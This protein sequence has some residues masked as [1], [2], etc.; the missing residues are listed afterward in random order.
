VGLVGEKVNTI[1]SKKISLFW[2]FSYMLLLPP[3]DCMRLL[4][5]ISL[6]VVVGK[7]SYAQ[8]QKQIH[9][10][11]QEGR[12][13][14]ALVKRGRSDE[15]IKLLKH[16]IRLDPASI[17]YPL[18]I[19]F[20]YYLE[21]KYR[22]AL[23]ILERLKFHKQVNSRVYQLL[24]R[25]YAA[26]KNA[27]RQ[28][29]ALEKGLKLFPAAGNLHAE[30]GIYYLLSKDTVTAMK[31]FRK[32]AVLDPRFSTSFYYIAL[33][34]TVKGDL[35][36]GFFNGEIYINLERTGGDVVMISKLLFYIRN[37]LAADQWVTY[38]DERL[39]QLKSERDIYLIDT[40]CRQL[41]PD[42]ASGGGKDA[43]PKEILENRKRI[44]EAGHAEAYLYW[45]FQYGDQPG[46]NNWKYF[47]M[48]KW[49]S[50]VKWFNGYQFPVG[51]H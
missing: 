38:N 9:E 16:C 24:S 11:A 19:A 1:T 48:L 23:D 12:R 27:A 2:I 5:I 45:L 50:F 20:A 14:M 44:L 3:V 42:F 26:E 51:I 29:E 22:K 31:W 17:V 10:A 7:C 37:K 33:F 36:A 34:S 18:E 15:G 40:V 32:G 28:T 41:L 6:F 4:L 25:C 21:Q 8:N 30:K 43:F 47:N 46:F 39:K 49:T 35:S 13:A